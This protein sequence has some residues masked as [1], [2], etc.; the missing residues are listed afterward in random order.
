MKAN[1][2][3]FAEPFIHISFWAII[4]GDLFSSYYTLSLPQ[5]PKN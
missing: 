3:V 5:P 1:G 4:L 2:Q